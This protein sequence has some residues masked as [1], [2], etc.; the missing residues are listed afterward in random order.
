MHGMPDPADTAGTDAGLSHGGSPTRPASSLHVQ[1]RP[2]GATSARHNW[3]NNH[4]HSIHQGI[5]MPSCCVGQARL[6]AAQGSPVSSGTPHH[7]QF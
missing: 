2:F 3:D 5:A 1:T 7:S 6:I 4:A